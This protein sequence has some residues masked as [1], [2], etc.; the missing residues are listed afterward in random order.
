MIIDAD[1]HVAETPE[2]FERF[3]DPAYPRPRLIPADL[4]GQGWWDFGGPVVPR[5]AGASRGPIQGFAAGP[6][7]NDV[8]AR[9]AFI[10]EE[11]ID[12]QVVYPTSLIAVCS[13]E[14]RD[15][16]CALARA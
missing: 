1:A 13:F 8:A 3:L 6:E 14:N 16:A 9:R 11:R 5:R 4:W 2:L 15:Y 10:E 12:L 7:R